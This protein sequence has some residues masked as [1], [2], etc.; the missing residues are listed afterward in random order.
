MINQDTIN[1]LRKFFSDKYGKDSF[2]GQTFFVIN[3]SGLPR[4][5]LPAVSRKYRS[6]I[7]EILKQWKP[8]SRKSAFFWV[9]LINLYRFGILYFIPGIQRSILPKINT[10][11]Y[12]IYVGTPGLKQK[13]VLS[14]YDKD[15]GER[16]IVKIAIGSKASQSIENEQYALTNIQNSVNTPCLLEKDCDHKWLSQTFVAGKLC[17]SSLSQS[18]LEWLT[19]LPKGKC[20]S[21][22]SVLNTQLQKVIAHTNDKEY[23]LIDFS[24]K[25]IDDTFSK[26]T[27]D[28]DHVAIHGDFAP[29]NMKLEK[30]NRLYVFDWESYEQD[31][32]PLYDLCYYYLNLS[33]LFKQRNYTQNLFESGV[34]DRY[35]IIMNINL[36]YKKP[37]LACAILKIINNAINDMRFDFAEYILNLKL[38]KLIK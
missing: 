29:W 33:H 1:R 20:Y 5:L 14:L 10:I 32:I 7:Y 17:Q 28:L 24:K 18:Q 19:L 8:Y 9:I 34:I 4:W 23:E 35:L 36:Y 31:G 11:I 37:L 16:S 6:I 30:N 25:I 12:T 3:S 27:V 2:E 15:S 26:K 22:Y 21:L 38:E 13:L